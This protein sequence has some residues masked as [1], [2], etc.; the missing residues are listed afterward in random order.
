MRRKVHERG[1][2]AH[3]RLAK[4]DDAWHVGKGIGGNQVRGRAEQRGRLRV[5][6]IPTIREVDRLAA[7]IPVAFPVVPGLRHNVVSYNSPLNALSSTAGSNAS[8]SAAV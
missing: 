2:L 7:R 5:A 3:T 1:R 4:Q 8:S 6:Q